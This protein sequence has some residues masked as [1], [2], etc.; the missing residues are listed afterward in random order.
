MLKFMFT[1]ALA[2]LG[3]YSHSY[4]FYLTIFWVCPLPPPPPS[5]P[6]NGVSGAFGPYEGEGTA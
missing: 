1:S 2:E 3:G 5:T 6:R 4:A